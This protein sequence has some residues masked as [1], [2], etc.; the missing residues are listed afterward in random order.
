MTSPSNAETA[1]KIAA[2]LLGRD[3][4]RDEVTEDVGTGGFPEAA[5]DLPPDED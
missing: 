1:H 2:S 4:E 3:E 5:Q